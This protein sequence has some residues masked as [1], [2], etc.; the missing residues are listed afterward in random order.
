VH[1]YTQ[2]YWLR[3]SLKIFLPGLASNHCP[4]NLCLPSSWDYR[5][6]SLCP[7]KRQTVAGTWQ[8]GLVGDMLATCADSS[9]EAILFWAFV[10]CPQRCCNRKCLKPPGWLGETTLRPQWGSLAKEL[11][12]MDGTHRGP[13][14]E[15]GALSAVLFG[16]W[17]SEFNSVM[18]LPSVL[19]TWHLNR[20]HLVQGFQKVSK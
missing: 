15:A 6:E 12:S 18:D 3:W 14:R 19:K 13:D 10:R 8:H 11:P 20:S 1:H 17:E 9:P 4:P 7:V 16:I 2:L 5:C